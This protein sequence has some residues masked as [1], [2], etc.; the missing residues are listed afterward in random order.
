MGRPKIT[1]RRIARP[2]Q[3]PTSLS[4]R[5]DLHLWSD[6]EQRVPYGKFSEF[7]SE[8]CREKLDRLY[9]ELGAER[10]AELE[11]EE[12]VLQEGK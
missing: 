3:I 1:D 6:L 10:A 11:P 7:V 2:L 9:G 8:A 12:R 4:A 5:I